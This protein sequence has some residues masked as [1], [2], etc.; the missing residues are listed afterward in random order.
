MEASASTIKTTQRRRRPVQLI[1]RMTQEE[2]DFILW[3]MQQSGRSNLNL[4]ALKM[5]TVGEVKNVD[6]THYHELAKEVSR[7]GV[8]INQIARFVN[9]NGNIYPQEIAEL[10]NKMEELWRLLKSNLSEQR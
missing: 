10:Q 2:K 9:A 4:Y 5:L 8:N 1:I 7:V 3:K 6:L